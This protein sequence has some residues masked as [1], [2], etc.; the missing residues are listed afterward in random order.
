MKNH[1]LISEAEKKRILNLH[2][3]YKHNHGTSLIS[4]QVVTDYDS[5]YD[6]KKEGNNYFTKKKTSDS[7]IKLSGNA[8]NTVK[9]KVF[10]DSST[11]STKNTKVNIPFTNRE[12]GNKF[13]EWVND[14]YPDYAKSED[15]WRDGPHDNS[16]IINAFKIYG[17]EYIKSTKPKGFDFDFGFDF[18]SKDKDEVNKDHFVFYF[19]LPKYEPKFDKSSKGWF[20]NALDWARETFPQKVLD[21]L[22]WPVGGIGKKGTYGPAGHAGVALINPAGTIDIYEFGRYEGATKGM[23]ITIHKTVRGAKIVD[24]EIENLEDVCSIVKKN[25]QSPAQQYDMKGV[26]IPITKEGYNKGKQYAD[27]I[28]S[29]KYQIFDFTTG[30]KDANCATFGLEVVRAA[31]GSGVEKCFPSPGAAITIAKTYRG[32]ESTNC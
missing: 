28:K 32:S 13:R 20:E 2:N 10:G 21:G 4:E 25:A 6:Y 24:G 15:F 26:A 8:L 11:Q 27:S 16:Y 29:K 14:K 7:W 12:E 5:I 3:S 17:D 31:T 19:S 1:F 9:S 18:F 30:D 22:L 23:G